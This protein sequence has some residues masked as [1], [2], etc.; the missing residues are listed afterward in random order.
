VALIGKREKR[1]KRY[2][3]SP[4]FAVSVLLIVALLTVIPLITVFLLTQ[5]Y[6]GQIR[7]ET[8]RT[9]ASIRQ[10]VR[11]FVDGAYD[12]CYELAVNPSILTMDREM[13]SSIL[14]GSVARNDYMEL[15]YITG[16]DGMQIA[17][18]SG[19]LGDRSERFWFLHIMEH[20]QPFV[21]RSY[22]SIN[23]GMPCTAIFIPMVS[24]SEMIA[25]FGADIN[26]GYIQRLAEHFADPGNGSY[27]F[28]IDGEGVVIAHP[29]SEILET[30]TNY[31]SMIRTVPKTDDSGNVILNPD[32]SVVIE[33]EEFTVSESYKAVIAAVMDG[34]SGLEMVDKDGVTYYMSYEPIDLPGSSD[35]W[36]VITLQDRAVAMGVV[37]QLTIQVLIIVVLIFVVFIV[38]VYGFIKSLRSTLNFLENA[39]NEA[40]QANR[41]K[42]RF[43]ANMSHEI[44]TPMNAIIGMTV[45]GKAAGDSPRKD[46]CFDKI[47][48]ASQHLLGVINDVLDISKIEAGKFALAP[49]Q[50]YFPSLL[51]DIITLSIIRI[52]D[53]PITFTLDICDDIYTHLYGDDLRLKQILINLLSNAFKYTRKGSVTLNINCEREEKGDVRLFFS[54]VDTG[55]GMREEDMAKLFSDYNQ[56]DTRA[57]RMIEGTGLGLSIAKG[58]AILMGGD[59]SVESEYGVGSVFYLSIRQ[60]FVS[61]ERVDADTLETLRGFRYA[62]KKSRDEKQLT[63]AD[64]SWARV[65]VVDDSPTNLDVARGLLGRYKMKVDCVSNGHGRYRGSTLDTF[66]RYGIY[67]NNPDNRING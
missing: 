15:Q 47:D 29:D 40:E 32:G 46:Y 18:S 5:A 11:S 10:T 2:P 48:S 55:I 53:K 57:N 42:T 6:D 21:S 39:R 33:E 12:L 26:L 14:A 22:Y 62:D 59:I 23:T 8:S 36:S 37:S 19:E 52:N 56:V 25:I 65:L 9:S 49:E 34:N 43:L 13:Q 51:N 30:L 61:D 28:I 66:H 54:V 31:K 44:R 4:R 17:R 38:L 27:S 64:L 67:K 7:N 3:I 60:G 35:S 20:K 24:G 63:R 45:A 50:Y 41:S 16:M 58:L 1:Q